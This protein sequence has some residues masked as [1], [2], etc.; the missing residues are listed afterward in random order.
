M[1]K[2]A[3]LSR[4][5]H[6]VRHLRAVQVRERVRQA[7]LQRLG[8]PKPDR[9][10]APSRRAANGA[11]VE[12]AHRRASMTGP[13]RFVFLNEERDL[14]EH[15]WDDSGVAI[16][17]RYN[18]HY[19]DDL[20]AQGAA[21][22]DAWH[23]ALIARWIRDNPPP[24]RKTAWSPYPTS[25]RIVN[26]IKWILAGNEPVPGMVD[27]LAVQAR[28]L[29]RKLERHLM[30]NHLFV[31]AKAL[32]FAGLFFEGPEADRWL[33][34]GIAILREEIDEQ[35]LPD[36]A[37]FERSPMYHALAVED[38]LDLA[39]VARTFPGVLAERDRRAIDER[40]RP[41]RR[42]LA[43]MCHPDGE[44]SFFNDSAIGIAPSPSELDAY[45]ARLG[46]GGPVELPAGVMH[47]VDAGFIRVSMGR[48]VAI[49]DVGPVGPDYLPGHAHADTLSFELS[50]DGRRVIVNSG[51]G[52][53]GTGPER[54]RQRGTAAHTTLAIDGQDS[55][56]VW[57][58]FRC[59]R[60]ARPFGLR[61]VDDGR[62]IEVT[63][64]HDGY[65]R[66]SGSPVH[67]RTWVFDARGVTVRDAIEASS[68]VDHRAVAHFHL[69]VD[70]AI[71]PASPES[72]TSESAYS[73]SEAGPRAVLLGI[74][75][76]DATH[77]PRRNP[78][79][80]PLPGAQP[81]D[82]DGSQIVPKP[83]AARLSACGAHL[84]L[85]PTT[86][87]PEFG[88]VRYHR[89]VVAVLEAR[90]CITRIDW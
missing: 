19:F 51:T 20:C 21:A 13:T 15:G 2:L 6:T 46:L 52:E 48:V 68:M 61:I 1:D 34:T 76:A 41:M 56:E 53:Y 44:V 29:E 62:R 36:G 67:T 5:W 58:G 25:M 24:R 69:A 17:W 75:A 54:A 32:V 59:A 23:R 66:L 26:W 38:M 83:S 49:L 90:S 11:F 77:L 50:L 82:A 80:M 47:F 9:R 85:E 18:L 64:S 14:E 89:K 72:T 42:Y 84:S 8:Y 57:G 40:V 81:P 35:I 79:A 74:A 78:C 10:P 39:N 7:L 37:Q 88:L 22:R 30:G 55:S 27:S 60:R 71:E 3:K 33:S 65:R 70:A 43:A 28:W 73:V 63:C 12:V 45:A 4:L 31:N 86:F 87:H 16:L